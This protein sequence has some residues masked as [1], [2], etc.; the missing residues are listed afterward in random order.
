MA[1]DVLDF[2]QWARRLKGDDYARARVQRFNAIHAEQLRLSQS[3]PEIGFGARP[4]PW[5]TPA[6]MALRPE[7]PDA[8]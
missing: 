1:A 8:R 6:D 4:G 5:F 2:G 3:E 7:S